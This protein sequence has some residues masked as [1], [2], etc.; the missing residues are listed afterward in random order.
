MK[1]QMIANL[2]KKL[3]LIKIAAA[4]QEVFELPLE[5]RR[6]V[7]NPESNAPERNTVC[8]TKAR[9]EQSHKKG[10][11]VFHTSESQGKLE[12][13]ENPKIQECSEY[14]GSFKT[15]QRKANFH[16]IK[17]RMLSTLR[18]PLTSSSCSRFPPFD[19]MTSESSA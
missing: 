2:R 7:S 3:K 8:F 14:E 12:A 15:Q 10:R 17:M 5:K 6:F 11:L 18:L 9:V 4:T 1:W 16:C 13:H 19:S